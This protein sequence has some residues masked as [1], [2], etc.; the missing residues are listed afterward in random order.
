VFTGLTPLM[1]A[2]LVRDNG[3]SAPMYQY[4]AACAVTVAIAATARV[5]PL[6]LGEASLQADPVLGA[7]PPRQV[8]T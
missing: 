1:L 2:W 7:L 3:L 5:M 8:G 6:Y 4:L